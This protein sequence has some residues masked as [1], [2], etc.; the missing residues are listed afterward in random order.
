MLT[1]QSGFGTAFAT[2]FQPILNETSLTAG[3]PEAATTLRNIATY[4]DLMVELRD[5]IQPEL[6]LIASRVTMPLKEYQD[7]LKKIRKTITKR[8]H[9]VRRPGETGGRAGARTDDGLVRTQLV[10][11]D[12]FNNS[13]GKLKDKKEKSLNDEKNLFKLEQ[14]LETATQEYEH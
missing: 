13:Y 8:D 14:D 12:R 3:H 5:A 2:L 9:K 1:A 4:Q 11:Y 7:L 6:D 10:D